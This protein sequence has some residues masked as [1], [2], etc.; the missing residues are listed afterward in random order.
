MVVAL[1]ELW[2]LVLEDCI[3]DNKCPITDVPGTSVSLV[4]RVSGTPDNN[5]FSLASGL[6]A[7]V[8]TVG[9][10]VGL[11]MFPPIG[12]KERG[13][14]LATMVALVTMGVLAIGTL[15]TGGGTGFG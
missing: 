4:N 11:L 5:T 2:L 3:G 13:G 8:L 7:V 9:A 15:T 14:A 1:G 10:L 12:I 6:R